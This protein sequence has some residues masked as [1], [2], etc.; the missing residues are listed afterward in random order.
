M[1]GTGS[2][3]RLD[4]LWPS[5]KKRRRRTECVKQ[6]YRVA[7]AVELERILE[8]EPEGFPWFADAA[9]C[10]NHP[11]RDRQRT[12]FVPLRASSNVVTFDT[13]ASPSTK[14]EPVNA[15]IPAKTQKA[16]ELIEQDR[17]RITYVIGERKR[18]RS[19]GEAIQ[20]PRTRQIGN[21]SCKTEFLVEWRWLVPPG[22]KVTWVDEDYV[23]RHA[24][25]VLEIYRD[26]ERQFRDD[27]DD[28]QD[29]AAGGTAISA[30]MRNSRAPN[31]F[32]HIHE[33]TSGASR[34]RARGRK[35]RTTS[36]SLFG[37]QSPLSALQ[38]TPRRSRGHS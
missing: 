16:S 22:E 25:E 14:I 34:M 26:R 8:R 38:A 10:T 32:Q 35:P 27:D 12:C 2:E 5:K 6:E 1:G 28:Y 17:N 36:T 21:A 31:D 11:Q 9:R 3:S 18:K 7:V 15:P 4:A 30:G 33:G 37:N 29:N 13:K 20:G 24:P 23:S 19:D